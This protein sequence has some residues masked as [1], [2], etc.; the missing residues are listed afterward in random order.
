M[1]TDRL[2]GRRV[3]LGVG[4]GIAAYK[5]AELVRLLRGEGAD[6]QVVMTAA[7]REFV[8]PLTFQAL[9]GRPVRDALFDPAHEAAMGHI[10]LAR[11]GEVV[12]VCPASANRLARLAHGLADDLL[13]TL[14]L[15][16]TAPLAVAPAMN[17]AMWRHPATQ[18]NVAQIVARGVHVWGPAEGA[19]ACGDTG[20]GRLLEPAS[21]L[22]RVVDLLSG[23][24]L[25]GVRVLLTAGPTREPID[26]VRF[27]GNRSSGKMGFA[28]AAALR[29]AGADVTL[30]AGPV[31]LATP[32]GVRRVDVET[33]AE[34]AAAVSERVAAC[35]IFVGCAAVADYRPAEPLPGK[36]KKTAE[37]LSID[38]VRN[39]D[40][41]A[42]VAALPSAPF[43]V[44]FAAETERLAE[45]AEAKRRAK[46]IDLIAANRVGGPGEGF[47]SDDNH[48]LALWDGGSSDLGRGSKAEL[49][50]ALARLIAERFHAHRTDQ[51]PGRPARA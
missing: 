42:G 50:V 21:L 7:A 24:P 49:A 35:E 5:A 51:D 34:M 6:V 19:Q 20:P 36:L 30:V 33:A 12:L 10:E 13:A 26:P 44:G 18:A 40:I 28:L 45:Q 39:P 25:T 38:M 22:R 23:G 14:C 46:A 31:P 47:E 4:G 11:W 43:T 41:L 2:A 3:L 8:A 17:Q 29:S 48:L 1:T 27:V 32:A 9:S 16:A 15:A 37:R